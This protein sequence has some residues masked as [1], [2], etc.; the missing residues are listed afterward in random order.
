MAATST[1]LA[2]KTEPGTDLQ[3]L[4]SARAKLTEELSS[5]Q[6]SAARLRE[7]AT[8]E[9]AVLQ[10]IGELGRAEIAA[11]T[12]W[13]AKGCTGDPP[14]PDQKQRRALAEKLSAAQAGAVAAKGAGEGIDQKIAE[15]NERIQVIK[16]QIDQV[17]FATA[18]AEHAAIITRYQENCEQ[19]RKLAAAIHGLANYYGEVGRALIGRGDQDGGT[20]Y[21]RRSAALTG[22]KLPTP[23]VSRLD[24]E[25]AAAEWSRRIESLRRSA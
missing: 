20:N 4:L 8:A 15:T 7:T 11:M 16:A 14:T 10:E 13:A 2:S 24:I 25:S 1:N 17:V 22:I 19:G 6:V 9:A 18:E 3:G 12:A 21:A 5:L 23:G